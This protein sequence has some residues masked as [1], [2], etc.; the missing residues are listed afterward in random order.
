MNTY[1]LVSKYSEDHNIHY[2]PF[3]FIRSFCQYEKLSEH[4]N[5]LLVLVVLYH[6]FGM[7]L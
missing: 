7:T 1:Q 6:Y 3:K 4:L 2:Y 5:I